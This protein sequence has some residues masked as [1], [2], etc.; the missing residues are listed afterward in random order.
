MAKQKQTDI[1]EY[2]EQKSYRERLGHTRYVDPGIDCSKEPSV[3]EQ[4]HKDDCDINVLMK[5]YASGEII[6]HV[7]DLQASFGDFS[8]VPDYQEALNRVN[9]ARAAFMELPA[10][11]RKRFDN[12]PGQLIGFLSDEKN[13]EEAIKLGLVKP[14]QVEPAAGAKKTGDNAP[15]GAKKTGD[16]A[17]GST[18]S[19]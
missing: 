3:T 15:A 8:D 11:T 6:D 4:H 17:P 13:T 16:N 19:T 12:D 9:D 5:R 7:N 14:R 1:E 2:I 10:T 18:S